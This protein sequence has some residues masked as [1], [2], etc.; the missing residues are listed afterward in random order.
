LVPH[1]PLA[2][3]LTHTLI[4]DNNSRCIVINITITSNML[5]LPFYTK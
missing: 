5:N 4:D 3:I 1:L 2:I